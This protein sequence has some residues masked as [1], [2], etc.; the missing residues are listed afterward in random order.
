MVTEIQISTLTNGMGWGNQLFNFVMGC[1]L[2]EHY[3]VPLLVPN[4]WVGWKL[5]NFPSYVKVLTC[6]SPVTE[7]EPLIKSRTPLSGKLNIKGNFQ[8]VSSGATYTK[9]FAQS[10]VKFKQ[11]W[12][13]AFKAESSYLAVHIRRGDYKNYKDGFY[14]P[15]DSCIRRNVSKIVRSLKIRDYETRYVYDMDSYRVGGDISNDLFPRWRNPSEKYLDPDIK[16]LSDFLCLMNAPVLM[17]APSTFSYWAGLLNTKGAV[18]SPLIYPIT[19]DGDQGPTPFG[20]CDV[21]FIEGNVGRLT[22]L[23]NPLP[24]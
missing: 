10:K 16:F 11:G 14:L 24:F 13:N 1:H 2:A 19:P 21:D 7:L 6:L 15:T 8:D 18:Y 12:L 3:K 20:N 23:Y 4:D 5:L 17:R 22:G 9:E